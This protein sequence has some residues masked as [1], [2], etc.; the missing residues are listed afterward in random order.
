MPR[1]TLLV[2]KV[3]LNTKKQTFPSSLSLY[4]FLSFALPSSLSVLSFIQLAYI[5]VVTMD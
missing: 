2:L 3:L 5:Y 4:L 1:Y